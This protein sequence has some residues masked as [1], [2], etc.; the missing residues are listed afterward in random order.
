MI[1]FDDKMLVAFY[2]SPLSPI[3]VFSN[4]A[5]RSIKL[6]KYRERQNECWLCAYGMLGCSEIQQTSH[7]VQCNCRKDSLRLPEKLFCA[8][9]EYSHLERSFLGSA[10]YVVTCS[11]GENQQTLS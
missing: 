6:K 9:V 11:F 7:L 4:I 8:I 10:F 5:E 2:V 1:L 3:L